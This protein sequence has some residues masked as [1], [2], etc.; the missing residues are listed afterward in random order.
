MI[1]YEDTQGP[2][3]LREWEIVIICKSNT[4]QAHLTCLSTYLCENISQ[5][6]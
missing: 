5:L 6:K 4:A 3:R 1:M 2:N